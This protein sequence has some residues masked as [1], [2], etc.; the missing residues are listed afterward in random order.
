MIP[1]VQKEPAQNRRTHEP[2]E[3]HN[4]A[5]TT[6]PPG[7]IVRE[8]SPENLEFPFS[9]LDNVITPNESFYVRS[10]FATPEIDL[11]TWRLKVDGDAVKQPIELSFEDLLRFPQATVTVTLECAGNGRVFIPTKQQG[12]QWGP[13]AVG[14]AEWTGIWLRDLLERVG[15]K[16]NAREVVLEGADCGELDKEPKTPGIIPYSH[17][18]PI[19]KAQENVLLACKMNGETLLAAH[20]FPLRA[21]VPGWYGMACVKWLSRIAVTSQIYTGYFQ[22][23]DYSYWEETEGLPPQQKPVT[24]IEVK[25]QIARPDLHEVVPANSNYLIRGAAWS[26][27]SKIQKVEVSVDGGKSWKSA[28]I[29]TEPT[30]YVWTFWEYEWRTPAAPG[31]CILMARATDEQTRTQ[32]TEHSKSRGG[33]RVNFTTPVPVKI[34]A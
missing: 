10:H 9:S 7:L 24:E 18:V 5:E 33:Y 17:S 34:K 22:T 20:G 14:T 27:E 1:R 29:T 4:H 21:V 16:P 6:K 32:P 3:V 31:V 25:A 19:H 28:K 15:V 12:V 26:G 23:A 30:Q 11:N 8:H 2:S 13:G